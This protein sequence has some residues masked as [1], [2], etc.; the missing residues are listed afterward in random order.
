[1]VSHKCHI[2]ATG[3]RADWSRKMREYFCIVHNSRYYAL[4]KGKYCWKIKKLRRKQHKS[5][6]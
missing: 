2:V 6:R 5:L 1:M 4:K 3:Y